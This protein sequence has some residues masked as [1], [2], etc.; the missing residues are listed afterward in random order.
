MKQFLALSMP[1]GLV[2][3]TNQPYD[4]IS[5]D[6][7]PGIMAMYLLPMQDPSSRQANLVGF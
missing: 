3:D 7:I 5:T 2:G 6:A 1:I 4:Y